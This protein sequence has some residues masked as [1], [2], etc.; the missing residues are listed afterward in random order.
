MDLEPHLDVPEQLERLYAEHP[1]AFAAALEQ[2]AASHAQHLMVR[3]WRARLRAT[4]KNGPD[5]SAVVNWRLVVALAVAAA[6]MMRLLVVSTD[7][8]DFMRVARLG[9]FVVL[10]P[11]AIILRY[12]QPRP[13]RLRHALLTAGIVA[14]LPVAIWTPHDASDSGVLAL[15]HLPVWLGALIFGL[16]A[17]DVAGPVARRA[18]FVAVAA[19]IAIFSAALT[20][21]GALLTG[22]SVGVFGLIDID[23]GSLVAKN[24]V[25][26]GC[27]A[28]PVL[29]AGLERSRAARN[30]RIGPALARI[31]SPLVLLALLAYA[32][33][34]VG[35]QRSPYRDRDSLALLYGMLLA[36]G[37]LVT[38]TVLQPHD[39][40]LSR[41]FAAITSAICGLAVAVDALALSA[42]VY[43]FASYGLSPNRVAVLGGNLLLFAY[44]LGLTI[45]LARASRTSD[46]A[47][48]QRWIAEFIPWFGGWAGLWVF[49]FPAVFGYR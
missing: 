33:A 41:R 36:T 27:A 34:V 17:H 28:I 11:V 15:S 40:P 38:V 16:L 31:F 35:S 21:A 39:S 46:I 6:G 7:P 44:L 8:G 25:L 14:A 9:A 1:R 4:G 5:T 2:L 29:A 43:R 26:P 3:A 22:M 47:P 10:I 20:F 24:V 49:V 42:I 48:A 13:P 45:T 30:E 18:E 19:E 32:L 12:G 23:L 37:L